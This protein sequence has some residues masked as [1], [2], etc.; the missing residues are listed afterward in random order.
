VQLVQQELLAQQARFVRALYG[1]SA[2]CPLQQRVLAL[3]QQ[4]KLQANAHFE[5]ANYYAEQGDW[6][7]AKLAT[8]RGC[9]KRR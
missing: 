7:Q 3:T 9:R 4:P 8:K 1:L 2:T 6:A 5:L